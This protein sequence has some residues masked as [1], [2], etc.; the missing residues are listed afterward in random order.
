V[1][2][3][4]EFPVEPMRGVSGELPGDDARWAYEVKWDGYRTLAFV[5]DGRVRLQSSRGLDVT[6]KY[7][8]LHRL[9]EQVHA[10]D[11][12]VDGEVVVLDDL[13]RPRFELLQRHEDPAC[14]VAFD[15]LAVDGR[16]LIGEPYEERRRLLQATVEPGPGLI[17]TAH[18][19]GHGRELLAAAVAQG[20]EGLMA[21]R[22]GST[23]QPGRRTPA[24][25]K[26]K[27]RRRQ[28]LVV[29]GWTPGEGRR[30]GVFGSLLVG[31]HDDARLRFGGGVGSGFNDRTLE[32]LTARLRALH[33]DACP[34]QPPP[35]R[36]YIRG[37]PRWVRPEIVVEVAFA[38]WTSEGLVRQASFLGVREDKLPSEVVREDVSQ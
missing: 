4:L 21:K 11:A 19:I 24:W 20:L 30:E 32:A 2:V 16:E 3:A 25:R 28:E 6:A 23:Y 10:A 7:R 29:G 34:F 31:Y 35:P 8:E 13:G 18:H 33:T 26:I 5:H 15:L 1:T 9:P 17:V 36:A 12:I 27:H 14:Y 38:E 37:N 22:L